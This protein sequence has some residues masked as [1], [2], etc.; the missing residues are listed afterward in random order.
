MDKCLLDNLLERYRAQPVGTGYIDVIVLRADFQPFVAELVSA[1]FRITT[2]SWWEYVEAIGRQSKYGMG[3]PISRYYPG[4]FAECGS[5]D[6]VIPNQSLQDLIGEIFRV[7][8]NK[9]LGDEIS[10]SETKSLTP[11]VWLDVDKTWKNQL[12]V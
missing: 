11:A 7:V 3:G 1:G 12:G 4:R 9:D 5:F 8:D 6:E 10:C 2:I